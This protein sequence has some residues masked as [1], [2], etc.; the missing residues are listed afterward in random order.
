MTIVCALLLWVLLVLSAAQLVTFSRRGPRQDVW[1]CEP[2]Q[3]AVTSML[4]PQR[5]PWQSVKTLR[6]DRWRVA[7]LLGR[8]RLLAT[9]P[10]DAFTPEQLQWVIGCARGAGVRIAGSRSRSWLPGGPPGAKS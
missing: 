2:M 1:L 9:M 7:L 3:I 8:G 4:G 5:V 10:R 6:V